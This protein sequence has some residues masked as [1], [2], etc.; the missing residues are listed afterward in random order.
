M[1]RHGLLVWFGFLESRRMSDTT[2]QMNSLLFVVTAQGLRA[3]PES[4]GKRQSEW[5]LSLGVALEQ[6]P[7]V[8]VFY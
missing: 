6:R 2:K 1:L 7:R 3:L 5:A 8:M 4:N